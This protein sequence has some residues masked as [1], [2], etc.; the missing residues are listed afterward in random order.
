MEDDIVAEEMR[1]EMKDWST[2]TE[3]ED[4]VEIGT[5]DFYWNESIDDY[6]MW[7]LQVEWI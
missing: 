2:T 1:K 5:L 7:V 6:N 4:E 3:E